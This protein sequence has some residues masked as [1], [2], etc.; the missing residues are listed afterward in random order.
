MVSI[1]EC[2]LRILHTQTSRDHGRAAD[3]NKYENNKSGIITL[4]TFERRGRKGI[5]EVPS[6]ATV[7]QLI[8][9]RRGCTVV[10]SPGTLDSYP[11][12]PVGT[13]SKTEL[14]RLLLTSKSRSKPGLL[15]MIGACY[16]NV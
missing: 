8:G 7:T 9:K 2:L 10:L 12:D 11:G 6:L 16:I 5:R 15:I 3:G 1:L 13:H 14:D 4:P